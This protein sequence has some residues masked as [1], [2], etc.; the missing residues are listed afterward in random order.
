MECL[1]DLIDGKIK[2]ISNIEGDT[3]KAKYSDNGK[4][5]FCSTLMFCLF[6]IIPHFSIVVWCFQKS[7]VWMWYL[8]IFLHFGCL[9]IRVHSQR[10]TTKINFN[11]Y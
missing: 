11:K 3:N 2:C 6:I 8:W 7:A 4:L 1:S 5:E 9:T 10:T